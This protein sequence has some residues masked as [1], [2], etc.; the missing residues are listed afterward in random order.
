MATLV[1]HFQKPATQSFLSISLLLTTLLTALAISQFRTQIIAEELFFTS[2]NFRAALYAGY[3]GLAFFSLLIVLAWTSR[4]TWLLTRLAGINSIALRFRNLALPLLLGLAAAYLLLVLGFYG[5]FLTNAFPRLLLFWF[6]SLLATTLLAA[7][8]GRSWMGSLPYAALFLAVIYSAATFFQQVNT[9]PLTLGWSEISR[10]YQASFFFS[11]QVYGQSLAWPITHPSRYLLQSLPFMLGEL[12][13]WAHRLWQALLWVGMTAL[14]ASVLTK[15]LGVKDKWFAAA[16]SGWIY[17]YLMQGAVF[18]H[19]LPAAL[20][21]LWGFDRKRFWRSLFLVALASAWAGISRINWAPLP[22]SLAALLYLID[23]PMPSQKKGPRRNYWKAPATYFFV[24]SLNALLAYSIYI[25]SS[26][27]EDLEQFSSSFTSALLWERLW[28]MAAFPTGI[29]P[30]ILLVSLPLFLLLGLRLR[31]QRGVFHWPRLL[32]VAI[33]FLVFFVGGLVVSV[34]IGGGTNLHNMD[35]FMV[36]LLVLVGQLAVGHFAPEKG[37]TNPVKLRLPWSLLTLL[38]LVPIL[39]AVLSGGPSQLPDQALAQE[40]IAQIEVMVADALD[41]GDEVLFISQR[42][43]LT[44]RMIDA[45]LVHDYEKLFLMEMA[46]SHNGAYLTRF[47]EDMDNQRF[48][49]IITDPLHRNIRDLSEDSLAPENNEWVRSVARKILCAYRPSL[50]DNSLS[51][52]VLEP[53]NE[54]NCAR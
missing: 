7:W 18:Y 21:V 25:S 41:A 46:I 48:G 32:A 15:R 42:H 26:G 33:V 10:Y 39:F 50:T 1:L 8:R 44:F 23:S 24:G 12:P 36:L 19:L 20:L 28:P 14:A 45:P 40:A 37:Q 6:F 38:L 17:L 27:V 22:G 11:E 9:Y 49:L 31:A 4:D 16:F 54:S 43:L 51:V 5:R 3:A 34:K 53:R 52:Q 29:L 35:A 13:L 30:G 47:A 2:A